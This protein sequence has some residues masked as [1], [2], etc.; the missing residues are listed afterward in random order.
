MLI[1]YQVNLTCNRMLLQLISDTIFPA[2]PWLVLFI[3]Q[4]THDV[5]APQRLQK[6]LRIHQQQDGVFLIKSV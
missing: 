4:Q 2:S 5:Q 3:G 6:P 1:T